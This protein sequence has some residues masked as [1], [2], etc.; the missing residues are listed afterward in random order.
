M[1]RHKLK[2]LLSVF[3]NGSKVSYS[4]ESMKL[5]QL[6]SQ[7]MNSSIEIIMITNR[8][9]K[10]LDEA[11]GNHNAEIILNTIF[12]HILDDAPNNPQIRILGFDHVKAVVRKTSRLTKIVIVSQEFISM[13]IATTIGIAATLILKFNKSTWETF[14]ISQIIIGMSGK[15]PI[16]LSERIVFGALILSCIVYSGYVYSVI[17]DIAFREEPQISN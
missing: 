8:N 4:V 6:L 2:F 7:S 14:N 17:L 1:H 3:K 13:I 15:E 16:K 10:L 5:G 12:L 11:L 9:L